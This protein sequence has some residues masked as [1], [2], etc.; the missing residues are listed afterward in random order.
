M[1]ATSY[2]RGQWA[3]YVIAAVVASGCPAS[4]TSDTTDGPMVAAPDARQP[5]PADASVP[6]VAEPSP[7]LRR[8]PDL[9]MPVD[10]ALPDVPVGADA[11]PASPDLVIR[12]DTPPVDGP[13]PTFDCRNLILV[14]NMNGVEVRRMGYDFASD[15]CAGYRCFT[16][17][18]HISPACYNER[19][20]PTACSGQCLHIPSMKL[21]CPT[22]F[23]AAAPIDGPKPIA[24]TTDAGDPIPCDRVDMVW[25]DNGAEVRRDRNCAAQAPST[26][27]FCYSF[28]QD[29]CD[30]VRCLVGN[31]IFP[32]C[33]A[34][35]ECPCECPGRCIEIQNLR[36]RCASLTSGKLPAP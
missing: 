36:S 33:Y 12:G 19:E 23:D 6:D 13:T 32:S 30:G 16:D 18:D 10:Q 14:W 25:K 34:G 9:A 21:Q 27:G 17:G 15:I 4:E 22:K 26:S 2:G 7:D 24:I 11:R 5:L 29:G 31:E 28:A 8:A 3:L 35:P 20:C 1:G